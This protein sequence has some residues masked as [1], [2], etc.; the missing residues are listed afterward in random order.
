MALGDITATIAN[1]SYVVELLASAT[2]TNGR[3]TGTAGIA[4]SLLT[5]LGFTPSN[6]RCGVVTTA[7]SATMT[8]TLAVWM[9]AG[10]LWFVAKYLN[11]SSAAPGVAVAIPESSADQ[12]QYSEVVPVTAGADRMYMEV[13]AIAGTSTAVTGYAI[14]GRDEHGQ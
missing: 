5:R 1:E 4:T 8:V 2:A 7:G 13:V 12:I 9:R 14:V 3:P 11:A 10:G 6:V